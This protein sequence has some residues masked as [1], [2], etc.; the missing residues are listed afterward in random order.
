MYELKKMERY[1]R[2]NLLRP[3]PRLLKKRIFRAA[4]SQRLRNTDLENLRE[5]KQS[6]VIKIKNK[7]RINI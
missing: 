5:T 1:L 3:D 7:Q 6:S 4:V 2:I